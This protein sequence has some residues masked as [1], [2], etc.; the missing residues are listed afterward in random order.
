MRVGECRWQSNDDKEDDDDDDFLHLGGGSVLGSVRQ[1]YSRICSSSF[2]SDASPV[3]KRRHGDVCSNTE[4]LESVY[5][6]EPLILAL[7]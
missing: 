4:S 7:S 3:M 6:K 1:S 5:E 2:S